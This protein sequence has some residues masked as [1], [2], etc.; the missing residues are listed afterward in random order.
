MSDE[1]D[2]PKYIDGDEDDPVRLA[3]RDERVSSEDGFVMPNSGKD[4]D[5]ETGSS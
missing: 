1:C 5:D 4:V 3:F 2:L